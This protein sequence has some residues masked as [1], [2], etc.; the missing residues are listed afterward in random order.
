ALLLSFSLTQLCPIEK[1]A[2]NDAADRIEY[3]YVLEGE[4]K[5]IAADLRAVA[6]KTETTAQCRDP[7]SFTRI[8]TEYLREISGDGHFYIEPRSNDISNDDDWLTSWRK[9]APSKG[10]GIRKVAIYEGNIGHLQISS[11]YEL[12]ASFAH[13]DAAFELL[14]HTDAL[15]LDLKG[16]S[17]GSPETE[18][19]LIWTFLSPGLG[20]LLTIESRI[21]SLPDPSEVPVLWKRYGTDRPLVVLIDDGTFSAPEA[22]AYTLQSVDRA[23]IIGEA[24]G[25]GAHL[26]DGG[27]PVGE[28]FTLYVP[29]RRPVG[30]QTGGNWEGIGVL[31]DIQASSEDALETAVTYLRAQLSQ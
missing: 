12:E 29:T 19:P 15:I 30:T 7:K 31:P 17:G 13:Y 21:E 1:A 9:G 5:E 10:Y 3:A 16:N 8:A 2:L 11:F 22:V 28:A 6:A 25:G 18:R 4:A 23:I 26:L 14:S 27:V 24:S 20:P